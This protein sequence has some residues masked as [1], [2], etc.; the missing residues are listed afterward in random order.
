MERSDVQ[1]FSNV[2]DDKINELVM[3]FLQQI[4]NVM[5][6]MLLALFEI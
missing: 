6:K 5:S 1:C 2:N 4:L 3:I